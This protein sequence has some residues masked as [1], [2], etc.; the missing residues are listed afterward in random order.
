MKKV[1]SFL[2][3]VLIV[4]LTM[5]ALATNASATACN[6]AEESWQRMLDA[7]ENDPKWQARAEQEYNKLA[8]K[9][10]VYSAFPQSD[11]AGW[12]RI[13]PADCTVDGN[14]AAPEYVERQLRDKAIYDSRFGLNGSKILEV[15]KI[16]GIVIVI[17]GVFI[18]IMAILFG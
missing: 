4:I 16:V 9:E 18:V 7:Y 11:S 12:H 3:A 14:P 2:F 5:T 15:L 8:K 10:E 17:A 1:V 13:R 6:M